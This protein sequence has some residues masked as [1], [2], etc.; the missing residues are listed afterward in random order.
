MSATIEVGT[1]CSGTDVE[2]IRRKIS[3]AAQAGFSSV[4]VTLARDASVSEWH[5]VFACCREYGLSLAAIGCYMSLLEPESRRLHGVSMQGALAA[6][7]AAA[8]SPGRPEGRGAPSGP[9]AQAGLWATRPQFVVWSGTLGKSLLAI[10][11]GNFSPAA[12]DR[13]VETAVDLVQRIAQLGGRLLV[14]PYYTHVLGRARDYIHFFNEVERRAAVAGAGAGGARAIGIVLDPPN[15][16]DAE[17]LHDL[18]A[19]VDEVVA[20]LGPHAGLAHFKDIT[21]PPG[22]TELHPGLPKP[23]AG[24]MDYRRLT[25]ALRAHAPAGRFV[26]IVEHHDENSLDELKRL[27]AFVEDALA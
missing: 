23:G 5:E 1:M 3:L 17:S 19:W 11:P 26:G 20:R 16:I 15:L 6:I 18:D 24:L 13:A 2:T 25:A 22:G 8:T 21:L 7:E 10:H 4:Q 12:W 9:A 27:K 14:E